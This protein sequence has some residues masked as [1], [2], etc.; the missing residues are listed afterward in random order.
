VPLPCNTYKRDPPLSFVP[1]VFLF[2]SI[3]PQS[4]PRL[5]RESYSHNAG[6]SPNMHTVCPRLEGPWQM[7]A[8]EGG[9]EYVIRALRG[10][11]PPQSGFSD[12]SPGQHIKS[13]QHIKVGTQCGVCGNLFTVGEEITVRK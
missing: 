5:I 6:V 3:Y 12:A 8:F 7:A 9:Y 1:L 13:T 4:N 2:I 10:S 11:G